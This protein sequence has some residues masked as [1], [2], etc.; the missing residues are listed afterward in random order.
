MWMGKRK[1]IKAIN[2][3]VLEASRGDSVDYL[4]YMCHPLATPEVKHNLVGSSL[5]L[6][7]KQTVFCFSPCS[8]DSYEG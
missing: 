3:L 2:K 4:L 6:S 1:K 5:G 7:P 8:G